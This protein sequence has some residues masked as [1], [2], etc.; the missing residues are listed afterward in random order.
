MT[1]LI[2]PEK[3]EEVSSL[4]L[5]VA[6]ATSIA[7]NQ[8]C[9]VDS[10]VRWPNDIMLNDRKLAGV[11]VEAESKGSETVY[12]AVG[13][14]L[15][16]NNLTS[17]IESIRETAISLTEILKTIVDRAALVASI[18]NETERLHKLLISGN[19][20]SILSLLRQHDWSRGKNVRVNLGNNQVVGVVDDYESLS[21]IR[22][23]TRH[24]IETVETATAES[25]EYES[26]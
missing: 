1:C 16:V 26:N 10:R 24:G 22:I 4:P 8:V 5:T 2:K 21:R 11:I 9:M 25:V 19:S 15:N 7:A 20:N 13:I 12:A 14:G 23:H 18:L 6:V 17:R 3:S